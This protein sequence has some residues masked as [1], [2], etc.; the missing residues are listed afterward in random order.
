MNNWEKDLRIRQSM[1]DFS[2]RANKLQIGKLLFWTPYRVLDVLKSRQWEVVD[3][4]LKD[5][6]YLLGL[7][8]IFSSLEQQYE[9][10]W[11]W[12]IDTQGRLARN[13]TD[14]TFEFT[15]EQIS[16]LQ[17]L[18]ELIKDFYIERINLLQ[19]NS[20]IQ[21]M[22]WID[23][24]KLV[25]KLEVP[26][27][28]RLDM[29]MT[30]QWKLKVVEIEPIYAG[31][32]ETLGTRNIY[33]QNN[34]I[35]TNFPGLLPSYN[36]ALSRLK[37]QRVLFCPNPKLPWY[38]REVEYLFN[39]LQNLDNELQSFD[40]SLDISEV[41]LKDDWVYFKWEK[42]DVL[43]NY[44]IPKQQ[45]EVS[46]FD[47]E[48]LEQF[49]QWNI[50]IFPEPTLDLDSK[51]WLAL[52]WDKKYFP[53][54]KLYDKFI[55]ETLL[56]TQDMKIDDN[57]MIKRSSSNINKWDFFDSSVWYDR[58]V[59]ESDFKPWIVQEKLETQVNDV[60]AMWKKRKIESNKLYSRIEVYLF[61]T[62]DW[63]ELWD[64]LV[65]MWP[66]QIV[67]WSRDCVMVPAITKK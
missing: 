47:K 1:I 8:D 29:V 43:I 33:N 19:N 55:P 31:I 62:E 7:N 10:E 13:I 57:R 61:F 5:I 32:W 60:I 27:F 21:T 36:N 44:Y 48:L 63:A 50:K 46:T 17:E 34:K 14:Y 64:I 22:F 4:V 42:I 67:K 52:A 18:P 23:N 41:S 28:T 9:S 66:R 26:L 56:Y 24:T 49:K 40:L 20:D 39:D 53:E 15:P 38:F 59:I 35:D 3:D 25:D 51:L 45:W 65:T 37:W 2:D 16:D 6:N 58:E 30:T 54:S 11:F 12:Y